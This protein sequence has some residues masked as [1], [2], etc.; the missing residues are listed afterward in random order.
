MKKISMLAI[1]FIF[2]LLGNSA[3]SAAQSKEAMVRIVHASPDAPAVDVAVNGDVVVEGAEFKAA[4]DFMAVPAGEHKVEIFAAGTADEGKPVISADLTV[5]AGKM[6]T[7]AAINTLDNLELKV[8]NDDTMTTNGKS[9]VRVGHFSP[10][11]PAV[12]V[13]IKGED[14]LFAGAEFSGVTEYM[15]VDPGSY[16][17]EVRPAGTMDSVLDLSGT[18]L[19]ENMTYTV[20]AVGFLEKEPALDAIVLED[21]M[22]PSGM[23]KT[24]MGGASE[25]SGSAAPWAAAGMGAV[26]LGALMIYGKKKSAQ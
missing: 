2:A 9:K 20:L 25:S 16:D 22:M 4:T 10:D 24:G 12:D 15:E 26:L 14:A 1:A 17:L 19:K 11:A 7:A 6:Y 3:A 5:E 23:P 13:G 18:E 21:P 8:L